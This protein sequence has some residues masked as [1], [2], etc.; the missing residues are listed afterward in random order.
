MWYT[1]CINTRG[2]IWLMKRTVMVWLLVLALVCACA[3]AS[4]EPGKLYLHYIGGD[5]DYEECANNIP[6]NILLHHEDLQDKAEAFFVR[7]ANKDYSNATAQKQLKFAEKNISPDGINVLIAYSHGGQSAFFMDMIADRITD[8]FLMD[9]CVHIGGKT[10]D[11]KTKGTV[12]AQWI[13]DTA[14]LGV[15]VH[16]FASIGKH[17]EP[18]GS[19]YAISALEERAAEDDSLVVLEEGRYQVLDDGGNPVAEIETGLLEGNHKT[20]CTDIE[21][22]VA[23]YLYKLLGE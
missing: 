14:K 23:E 7:A 17:N 21:D 22:H 5:A 10:K 2:E 11:D 9:A 6:R 3:A 19:K 4:A 16:L 1:V 8:V 15:N 20:I 12:W 18:S 13:I